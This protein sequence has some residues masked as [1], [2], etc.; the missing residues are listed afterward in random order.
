MKFILIGVKVPHEMKLSVFSENVTLFLTVKYPDIIN[1]SV[2]SPSPYT[3]DDVKSF[4]GP[5]AYN[6]LVCGWVNPS[7]VVN[8][9]SWIRESRK[10]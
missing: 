1:F 9:K 8:G 5:E 3:S 2:F 6:Q 4:K 7:R 10:M